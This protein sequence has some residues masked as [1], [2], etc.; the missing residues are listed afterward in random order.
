[1]EAPKC[2]ICHER[3]YGMCAKVPDKVIRDAVLH[4]TGISVVTPSQTKHIPIENTK[5]K[6]DRTVYQR[7][8]MRKRRREEK[9]RKSQP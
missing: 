3:H 7:E 9:L 8:L 5:P 2:K 6:F 1:M 4:G